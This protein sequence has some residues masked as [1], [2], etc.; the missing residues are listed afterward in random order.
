MK[1]LVVSHNCFSKFYNNGKTLESIFS[2]FSKQ[3]LAQI[4]FTENTS[5][6]YD[7][8]D[9]YFKMT[10]VNV[11]KSLLKGD[12]D[13]GKELSLGAANVPESTSNFSSGSRLFRFAKSKI[14][15]IIFFRDALWGLKSWKS[16]N[17]L[18]WN[19]KIN[20]N[21]IFYVG[22]NFGFSHEIAFFLSKKFKTPLVSYFTD[23]YLIFPEHRNVFDRIQRIRMKKFYAKTI[24]HSSLC[25]AIGDTMANEYAAFFKKEFYPIMNSIKIQDYC[26]YVEHKKALVFS[27]FGGLHLNRWRMLVRLANSLRTCV[28]NVYS[29]EKPSDAIL[30]EFR[31]SGINF[32]GAVEG[33]QLRS[34]IL[35]SD[36]LLHVESD[37]SFNRSLTKLS[38]STKIPEYL[39]SG[40]LVLGFGPEEVASM[41]IL[42][43]NKI[44]VVISSSVSNEHLK[45]EL[46][47]LTSDFKFRQEMG[48][49]GY[50]YAVK[51]FDNS[52]IANNFKLQLENLISK[53]EN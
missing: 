36:V 24:E 14:N 38:V 16:K 45:S 18:S 17:F 3:N 13:C 50:N 44:G 31:K 52:K 21:I 12:S 26:P 4:Y 9:N 23:D 46:V 30:L 1:I 19:E 20:P 34:S 37:D 28:V 47:K 29:V 22:G 32:K 10:D 33:I 39:M 42:A 15:Q 43:D 11:L 48:L 6:D 2:S 7:F 25:F 49:L 5:P 40:R 41:K 35:D 53:H 27:Y 8:C 51:N